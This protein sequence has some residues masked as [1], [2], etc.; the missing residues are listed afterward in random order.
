MKG[1]EQS[2][3]EKVHASV[4]AWNAGKVPENMD[5]ANVLKPSVG[6]TMVSAGCLHTQSANMEWP[7]LQ[8]QLYISHA[9]VGTS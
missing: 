2:N 3:M 1:T 7:I 5:G 4:C 9:P 8:T 6:R